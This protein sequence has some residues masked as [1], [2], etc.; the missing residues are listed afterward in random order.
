MTI[1][2]RVDTQQ[3]GR[4]PKHPPDT[5]LKANHNC[6]NL[7]PLLRL[8]TIVEI[9]AKIGGFH[10]SDKQK[11]MFNNIKPPYHN[12]HASTSVIASP[13]SATSATSPKGNLP[14]VATS[15]RHNSH[16]S[17]VDSLRP[18]STRSPPSPKHSMQG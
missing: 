8:S 12:N 16:A 17:N 5:N 1:P 15:T 2:A 11:R 4:V 7:M 14:D 9:A 18:P 6:E 13:N 3:S 10:K